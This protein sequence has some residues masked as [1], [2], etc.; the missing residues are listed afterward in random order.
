[1]PLTHPITGAH[2]PDDYYD[3][4]NIGDGTVVMR[5]LFAAV[6]DTMQ[7]L[8]PST[9]VRIAIPMA[10]Y[11]STSDIPRLKQVLAQVFD[12]GIALPLA[13]AADIGDPSLYLG[14][15]DMIAAV[16]DIET[17]E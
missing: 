14:W 5:D 7:G 13:D 2:L 1:M 10:L 3:D 12:M 17:D 8:N 9:S 15:E 4:I 6:D 11:V 16:E